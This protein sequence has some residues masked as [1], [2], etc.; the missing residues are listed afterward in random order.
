MSILLPL[1]VIVQCVAVAHIYG[2][3][4]L[5][6][7][8]K[9][10]SGSKHNPASLSLLW[11]WV[12]PVMLL[13]I[14]VLN[15]PKFFLYSKSSKHS[16]HIQPDVYSKWIEVLIVSI[17]VAAPII[18]AILL[19]FHFVST[20]YSS[21]GNARGMETEYGNRNKSNTQVNINVTN[22]KNVNVGDNCTT[23]E[24]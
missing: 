1:L 21:K 8:F 10:M 18:F 5:Q 24:C 15:V 23:I 20:S 7:D 3:E 6:E 13:A 2:L 17:I 9:F 4:K 14:V 12:F 16:R 22:C 19:A 11:K